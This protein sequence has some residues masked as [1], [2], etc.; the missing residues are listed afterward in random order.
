MSV[1]ALF[2]LSRVASLLHSECCRHTALVVA[3]NVTDQRIISGGKVEGYAVDAPAPRSACWILQIAP[4]VADSSAF[5]VAM[6]TVNASGATFD[7]RMT[8]SW[9]RAPVL[10]VTKV[11]SPASP[12]VA[13]R[14]M[15]NSLSSTFTVLALADEAAVGAGAVEGAGAGGNDLAAVVAVSSSPPHA[16]AISA[17]IIAMARNV[18]KRLTTPPVV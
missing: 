6:S 18:V 14:L 11:I 8:N 9:G 15:E 3:G 16:P 1:Q 17:N 13:S 4:P 2:A 5:A 10:V 7:R 12:T